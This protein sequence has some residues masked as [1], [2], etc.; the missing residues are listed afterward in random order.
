MSTGLPY[1][2]VW[3]EIG[4]DC[5]HVRHI[6]VSTEKAAK[7]IAKLLLAKDHEGFVE[8]VSDN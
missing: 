2:V 5:T 3:T 6:K 1:V 7:R 8:V 4:D